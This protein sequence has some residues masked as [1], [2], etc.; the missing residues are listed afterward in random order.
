MVPETHQTTPIRAVSRDFSLWR[1]A[2]FRKHTRELEFVIR[3][4]EGN[5]LIVLYLLSKVPMK[6]VRRITQ[7]VKRTDAYKFAMW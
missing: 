4:A 5:W 1:E 7:Y 3:P 2:S 6:W